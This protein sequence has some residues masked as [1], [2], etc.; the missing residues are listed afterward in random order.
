MTVLTAA[1]WQCGNCD[2]YYRT[3][4]SRCPRCHGPGPIEE[5][6]LLP[7]IT[8]ASGPSNVSP[9]TGADTGEVE[10]PAPVDVAEPAATT[11]D[12]PKRPPVN[13]PKSEW[14]DY[15]ETRYELDR[16]YLGEL[17][18]TG[19]SGLV[20][21][22]MALDDGTMHIVDGEIYP[23]GHDVIGVAGDEDVAV[24]EQGPET[25]EVEEG[26]TP[27]EVDEGQQPDTE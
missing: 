20:A 26:A 8:Q 17:N 1:P 27:A 16:G 22:L 15:G 5:E 21:T 13:A 9:P 2:S 24:G 19:D 14:V 12:G 18:K 23:V 11:D 6:P 25:V 3:W 10:P 4:L 7:K